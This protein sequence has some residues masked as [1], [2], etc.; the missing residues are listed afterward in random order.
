MKSTPKRSLFMTFKIALKL[1]LSELKNGDL[2]LLF[3]SLV[4]ATASLSSVGFL[5]Y[6]VDS[7]MSRHANQLNGAQLILKSSR[8]VPQEWLLEAE[9]MGLQQ[10]QMQVFTSMLVFNDEFKLA[11][12]KAVTDNFPLQGKLQIEK[13]KPEAL[14]TSDVAVQVAIH[15]PPVGEIWVDK[16]LAMAFQRGEE[17]SSLIELGELKL[18]ASAILRRVPGQSSS[19]FT[20][21][22]TAMINLSDLAATKTIQPGSRVDYIYFFSNTMPSSLSLV[23][24]QQWLE[25]KLQSGQSL[26]SGVDDLKAVNAS[27]KKAGDFLSLAAVLTVLLSAIAIAINTYSYGQKQYKNNAIM[28]CLGGSERRIILIELYKLLALGV[29]GSFTGIVTGYFAYLGLLSVLGQF[30]IVEAQGFF[31]ADYL[32]PAWLSFVCGL[33]LLLS[34]SMANLIRI[35]KISP[36]ELIYKGAFFEETTKEKNSSSIFRVSTGLSA[37]Y[38]LYVFSLSGLVLISV[39]YTGNAE[40][41]LKF[42]SIILISTLGLYFFARLL[43]GVL[44]KVGR[45]YQLINRMSLLNLERHKQAVLLQITT[46]SLIFSLLMIIFLVRTELLDSWKQKFPEHTPNHFV[47]NVQ[48]HEKADFERYLQQQAIYTKGIFPMVRGRLTFVNQQAVMDVIPDTA[49]KHNAL[50]RELNLSFEQFD[51]LDMIRGKAGISIESELAKSLNVSM[52]DELGFRVGSQKIEGIVSQIREVNWDS[53]QPN[54]YIIFSPGLIEQYPMTWISSFYLAPDDKVKLSLLM[55]KF[56]GITIIEV[57]EVLKEV[58]YI[59]SRVSD[60]IEFIFLFVVLA[61]GVIL[62]SSLVSTMASR[63][64]ENAIIRTLGASVKQ[65]RYY[66]FIELLIVALLSTLVAVILS[67]GVIWFLYREI[68]HM[69][70]QLHPAVWLGMAGASLILVCGLGMVVINKIFT[71]SAHRSLIQYSS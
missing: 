44:T 49:K 35:R 28:L 38:L 6:H 42:Y 34:L 10:A 2:T 19:L 9:N 24:Y 71:Q 51:D 3:F 63:I 64:Y 27:L 25:S 5:I 12:I 39:A 14:A 32:M 48:T 17:Y 23:K 11:K 26:R 30:L 43:L 37:R 16:R 50:H 67:E 55:K 33:F 46:F 52:G 13:I 36:I 60:A 62:S 69:A 57:D 59:I 31:M 56:P 58:Q 7:S 45:K 66:L 70:F 18:K 1:F 41:V 53:F 47:I 68:F 65:L 4:I 54:F 29:A 21:A 40:V 15:A 61:G 20:I 8:A 22:P